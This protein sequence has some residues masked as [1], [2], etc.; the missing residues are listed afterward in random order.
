M[1]YRKSREVGTFN[2]ASLSKDKSIGQQLQF[3][4]CGKVGGINRLDSAL[5][6]QEQ[7]PSP[8]FQ[9]SFAAAQPPNWSS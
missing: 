5:L 3:P 4:F 7:R 1:S 8:A 2:V 6:A 9:V